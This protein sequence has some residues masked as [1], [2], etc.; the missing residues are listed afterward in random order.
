MVCH[1]YRCYINSGAFLYCYSVPKI[2]TPSIIPLS[3]KLIAHGN[4]RHGRFAVFFDKH[5]ITYFVWCSL[6][7]G[8]SRQLY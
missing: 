2:Y 3:V 8:F 4:F 7:L 5:S 1:F 6:S